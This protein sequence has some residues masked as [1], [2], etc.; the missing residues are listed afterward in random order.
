MSKAFW[1]PV[2]TLWQRDLVRFW[3]EKTRVAGFV[4]SPL[5][6]WLV[7]GSGFNDLARFFPGAL[8]LT[9]M[10]SSIFSTMSI[11]EDRREGFLLSMLVSPAPRG[12]MVLGKLLGSSTLAWLQGLILLAF[13]PLTGLDAT[14]PGLAGV[15]GVMYLIS[16]AFTALGFLI[17]WKMD[18]SQGY[19]AVMNLVLFPLWMI[20][21]ALFAVSG[22]H[23][24]M[25][26]LMRVNPLTYATM[27]LDQLLG[28]RLDPATPGMTACLAVLVASCLVLWTAGTLAA[29][30]KSKRS[31][32]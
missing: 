8:T 16:F 11:I 17:A 23:G 21:G 2:L 22:A 26:L 1:L 30:R 9:V 3:R 14:A 7:I 4:G 18:S 24:W 5:V 20:S 6:F 13:L 15:A 10:F 32:A 29:R 31:N 19:H 12:A 28:A 27:A 25:Q